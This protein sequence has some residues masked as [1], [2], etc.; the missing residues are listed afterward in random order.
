MTRAANARSH[1]CQSLS[2]NTI[3]SSFDELVAWFGDGLPDKKNKD[4]H[5]S[6]IAW[7]TNRLKVTR[8]QGFMG[9]AFDHTRIAL[10]RLVLLLPIAARLEMAIDSQPYYRI[11]LLLLAGAAMIL[12]LA[13]IYLLAS[14]RTLCSF[15]LM[16]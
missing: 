8:G 9:K 11:L 3:S 14:E 10:L 13:F 1:R 15:C 7:H 12:A 6:W 16:G 4:H 5:G 2:I